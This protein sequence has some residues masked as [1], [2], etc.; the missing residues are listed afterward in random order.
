MQKFR[1][2]GKQKTGGLVDLIQET[3]KRAF[4]ALFQVFLALKRLLKIVFLIV[5]FYL[6]QVSV[7]P[8]MR[9]LDVMPNFLM[10]IIAV[11][12]VS[13]GKKYAFVSGA[14][15]GLML[16]S[17]N[18]NIRLF[19]IVI[20]PTLALLFAQV[21]ADMSELTREKRR[22]DAFEKNKTALEDRAII[23]KYPVVKNILGRLGISSDAGADMPPHL[24]ILLNAVSLHAAY[25]FIMLIYVA[26][27]GAP[28]T[29]ALMMRGLRAV[30]YTAV[31]SV[32]MFPVR[33]FLGMYARRRKV[34]RASLNR[35]VPVLTATDN[36]ISAMTYMQDEPSAG[37]LR[38]FDIRKK[39]TALSERHAVPPA[40][41]WSLKTDVS[42]EMNASEESSTLEKQDVFPKA[43]VSD[44]A[45]IREEMHLILKKDAGKEAGE[46]GEPSGNTD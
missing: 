26:L 28:V 19:Y 15:I 8:H 13:C 33:A 29:Y 4:I 30:L 35:D 9:M 44:N 11:L 42:G 36:A 21:F 2:K 17:V 37:D 7:V 31:C 38:S 1:F 12:T 16:E 20:Y 25:E 14:M 6:I 24:R 39:E 22:I 45:D 40:G 3:L 27:N 5:L 23:A 32:V 18:R 10:I 46:D 34:S 41:K 43:D